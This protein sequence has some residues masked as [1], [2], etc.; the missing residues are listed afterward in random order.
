MNK[1]LVAF[2]VLLYNLAI[3]AGTAYLCAEYDWSPWTFLATWVFLITFK[4]NTDDK[5]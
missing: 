5:H 2:G 4:E 3:V 1:T